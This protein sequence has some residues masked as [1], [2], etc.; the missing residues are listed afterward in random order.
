M[1]R[2]PAIGLL[3]VALGTSAPAADLSSYRGLH[4]GMDLAAAAKQA[5]TKTAEAKLIH[6]RPFRIQEME[7]Q[8]GPPVLADPIKADPVKD[9]L[10]CFVDGQLF[11]I[12]VTYDRYK[13]QGMTADDMIDA[14]S[15]H[16]G[17]PSRPKAEIAYHSNYSDVAAVLARWQD[18]E[19]SFD[20]VRTGDRS[21]FAM[22][23]YSKRLDA[24]AQVA[25]DEAVRLEKQEAPQRE[26][27]KQKI[28]EEEERLTLEKARSVN[29]ANF[30][31]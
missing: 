23:L 5:G 26:L 9:A 21:S 20:L 12:V 2:L 7:W 3:L 13:V 22:I 14:I 4:F 29:K 17:P 1:T 25:I 15:S 8:P 16:Y 30:H 24:M 18:S 6:Q 19:Y 31:P 11:R 28:R 27:E 10:L